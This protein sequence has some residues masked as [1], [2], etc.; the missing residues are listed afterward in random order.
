MMLNSNV[1]NVLILFCAA[2]AIIKRSFIRVIYL[3]HIRLI[4]N[5][6]KSIRLEYIM[7]LYFSIFKCLI[8]NNIQIESC[9]N[10][11][12]NYY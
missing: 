8:L 7:K 5:L 2:S 11:K 9:T 3:Q 4:M 6:Y 10:S 12:K 1:N